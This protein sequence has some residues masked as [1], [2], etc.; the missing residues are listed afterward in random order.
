[1]ATFCPFCSAQKG[2]HS[3]SHSDA[4]SMDAVDE[5][6]MNSQSV[7]LEMAESEE[8]EVAA[9]SRSKRKRPRGHN[10]RGGGQQRSDRDLPSPHRKQTVPSLPPQVLDLV[11][12]TDRH[13]EAI[14]ALFEGVSLSS[15]SKDAL[16]GGRLEEIKAVLTESASIQRKQS[17]LGRALSAE[18][19]ALR[20]MG[21]QSRSDLNAS[22]EAINAQYVTLKGRFEAVRSANKEK[23]ASFERA[24]REERRDGAGNE[25]EAEYLILYEASQQKVKVLD[26]ELAHLRSEM[27]RTREAAERAAAKADSAQIEAERAHRGEVQRLMSCH[28]IEVEELT[29][30]LKCAEDQFTDFKANSTAK[31]S[32]QRTADCLLIDNL[33]REN[34]A[35]S[36]E[37]SAIRQSMATLSPHSAA[38][39]ATPCAAAKGRTNDNGTGTGTE[40]EAECKG[41]GKGYD[42]KDYGQHIRA[43]PLNERVQDELLS[44]WKRKDL[45]KSVEDLQSELVSTKT[46]LEAKRALVVHFE[47][48]LRGQ[49]SAQKAVLEQM[50]DFRKINNLYSVLTA[51]KIE[52]KTATE[53]DLNV[54]GD[55]DVELDGE[56][57]EQEAGDGNAG[58]ANAVTMKQEV[59]ACR[60]AHRE[61]GAMMEYIL[62]FGC[63]E[64]RT[65]QE[66]ASPFLDYRLVSAHNLDERPLNESLSSNI[67]FY[68][69]NAPLFMDTVIRQMFA[70]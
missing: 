18:G 37:L 22:I 19:E 8:I 66:E 16:G 56:S 39:M 32:M 44:I 14:K 51:T 20:K 17:E 12:S 24:R 33:K 40:D 68:E 10:H 30:A 46:Q 63:N 3:H 28:R 60:T 36:N 61:R 25:E 54:D 57:K 59:F 2:T 62:S 48:L 47:A 4:E 67:T 27:A 38:I 49:Q 65:E 1:M 26:A 9:P 70:K 41:N 11:E 69:K 6:A 52:R 55:G 21:D 50:A 7:S 29:V 64:G 23:M 13:Q 43:S 53:I 34:V 45:E 5:S 58:N 35:L 31:T 42:L 15:P